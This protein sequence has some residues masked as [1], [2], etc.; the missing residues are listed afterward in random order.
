MNVFFKIYKCPLS[1]FPTFLLFGVNELIIMIL[2]LNYAIF[3]N[4]MNI[5]TKKK[6]NFVTKQNITSE[7]YVTTEEYRQK[8]SESHG[9]TA[10]SKAMGTVPELFPE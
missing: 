1:Y 4:A 3:F 5:L 9:C 7:L 6:S 2:L 8:V 10:D